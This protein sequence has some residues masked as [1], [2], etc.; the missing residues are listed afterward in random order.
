MV[1][2]TAAQSRKAEVRG[3]LQPKALPGQQQSLTPVIPQTSVFLMTLVAWRKEYSLRFV[4]CVGI[5]S[6][7]YFRPEFWGSGKKMPLQSASKLYPASTLTLHLPSAEIKSL[8]C[9]VPCFLLPKKESRQ[10]HIKLAVPLLMVWLCELLSADHEC[11]LQAPS[12]HAVNGQVR[13]PTEGVL[14]VW[15]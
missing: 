12:F 8:L 7:L 3:W 4:G 2:P 5:W 15:R 6:L 13:I 1:V 10:I 11:K 9:T 14:G